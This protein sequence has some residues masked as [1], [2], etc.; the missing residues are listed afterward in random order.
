MVANQPKFSPPATGEVVTT[1]TITGARQIAPGQTWTSDYGQL[2]VTRL[3]IEL[4]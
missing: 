3:E 4:T 2:G 1:G